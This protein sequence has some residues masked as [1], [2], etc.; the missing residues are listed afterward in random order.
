LIFVSVFRHSVSDSF[1]Y[2]FCRPC[3]PLRTSFSPVPLV[4]PLPLP[5]PSP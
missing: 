5:P 2:L 4:I 1:P 3:L